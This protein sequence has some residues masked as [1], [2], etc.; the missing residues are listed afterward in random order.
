MAGIPTRLKVAA[1]GP[2]VVVLGALIVAALSQAQGSPRSVSAPPASP[3]PQAPMVTATAPRPT[4]ALVLTAHQDGLTLSASLDRTTVEPGD[5]VTIEV[6]VH[7]GRATPAGYYAPCLDVAAMRT[8]LPLPLTPRGL[9]WTGAKA[10]L[11]NDVLSGTFPGE[12]SDSIVKDTSFE[13]CPETRQNAYLHVDPGRTIQSRLVW[14]ATLVAGVPALPGDVPFTITFVGTSGYPATLPTRPPGVQPGLQV[15]VIDRSML[16]V[17]GR[18]QIVGPAPRL[19]SKGEA[20]DAALS[21]P[22][23]ASW[24]AEEPASTWSAINVDLEP[25]PYWMIELLRETGVPRNF[26][27]AYVDPYTGTVTLDICESPCS[28]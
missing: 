11:K 15:W 12:S 10:T 18:I 9:T 3:T 5:A 17:E 13:P 20:V 4:P 2:I 21:D 7:N 14:T 1:A 22:R 19:L 25:G 26:A 6:A 24:L 23:F 28:R 8:N 16:H 27:L